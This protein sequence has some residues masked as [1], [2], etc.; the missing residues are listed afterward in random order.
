MQGNMEAHGGGR[1][2]L[3]TLIEMRECFA[4]PMTLRNTED[5]AIAK[6]T[7]PSDMA[8]IATI[9]NTFNV[10]AIVAHTWLADMDVDGVADQI[11]DM[12]RAA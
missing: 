5:Y 7:K 8:L 10:S 3:K 9:A 12:S 4:P 11:I 6:R 2:K 1:M